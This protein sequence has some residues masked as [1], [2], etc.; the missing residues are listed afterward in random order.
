MK[1]I[2]VENNTNLYRDS[3]TNAI[4]NTNT[5]EYKNYMNSLKY[6]KKEI[7]KIKQI[8]D[9]VNSVKQDLQEIKDLLRCLIKE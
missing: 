4:V 7:S 9:D 3:N 5:T 8:E 6:R 2:K 1:K